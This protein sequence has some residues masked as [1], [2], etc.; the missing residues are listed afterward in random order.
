MF[1]VGDLVSSFGV[2]CY[3]RCLM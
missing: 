1:D 3:A 2:Y